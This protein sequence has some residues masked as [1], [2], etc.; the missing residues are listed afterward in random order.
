[1]KFLLFFSLFISSFHGSDYFYSSDLVECVNDAERDFQNGEFGSAKSKFDFFLTSFSDL[2][3]QFPIETLR[4]L[5][6]SV[7]LDIFEEDFASATEQFLLI[8]RVIN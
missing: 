7:Y 1:M 8:N 2:S 4:A 6:A 5:S 3:S